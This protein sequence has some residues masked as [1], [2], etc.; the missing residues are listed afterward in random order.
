MFTVLVQMTKNNYFMR[1][2]IGEKDGGRS[3]HS[4]REQCVKVYSLMC[5][6][7]HPNLISRRAVSYILLLGS[8]LVIDI[9][10]NKNYDNLN[11]NQQFEIP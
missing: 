1:P 9:K 3:I 5:H 7:S 8:S 2:K 10:T 11:D 4:L 6:V